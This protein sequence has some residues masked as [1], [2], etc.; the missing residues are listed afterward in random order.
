MSSWELIALGI[1][2][3]SKVAI[4]APN[5][6]EWLIAAMATLMVGGVIVGVYRT[7]SA[8][9]VRYV[10]DHSQ[11]ALAQHR[12]KNPRVNCPASRCSYWAFSHF[13]ARTRLA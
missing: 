9:Q 6:P 8:K 5:R 12:G 3:G 4:R 1:A 2:P 11:A 10:I 13:S 7:A